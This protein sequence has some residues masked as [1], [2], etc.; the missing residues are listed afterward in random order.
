[1]VAARDTEGGALRQ[2]RDLW[3]ADPRGTCGEQS[4]PVGAGARIRNS[5]E[6]PGVSGDGMRHRLVRRGPQKPRARA[7]GAVSVRD[8]GGRRVPSGQYQ[9]RLQAGAHQ[10]SFRLCRRRIRRTR[11]Y[12]VPALCRVGGDVLSRSPGPARLRPLPAVPGGHQAARFQDAHA[13]RGRS[14]E[15]QDCRIRRRPH[16]GWRRP[17]QFLGHRGEGRRTRRDRRLRG[18]ESRHYHGR[19]PHTRR[20]RGVDARLRNHTDDDGAGNIDR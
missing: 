2:G 5:I 19:P 10:R 17:R 11:P 6:R 18:S 8:R 9:R 12:P 16:L 4:G 7:R 1:M 20:D 14:G 13:D 15:R 3:R